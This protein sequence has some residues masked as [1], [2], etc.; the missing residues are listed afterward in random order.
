VVAAAIERSV[1]AA[2]LGG[3]SGGAAQIGE[4]G[5]H[6]PVGIG[7][8]VEAV[9]SGR[10][11]IGTL[12]EDES[13]GSVSCRPSA[14]EVRMAPMRAGLVGMPMRQPSALVAVGVH[15]M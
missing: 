14:K 10:S 4:D 13:I 5:E 7:V 2:G 1:T 12:G 3:S 11:P 8:G 15:W 6:A 9:T